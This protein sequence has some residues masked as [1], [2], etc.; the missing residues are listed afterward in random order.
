MGWKRRLLP[1]GTQRSPLSPSKI[2]LPFRLMGGG[3]CDI[4]GPWEQPRPA[5]GSKQARISPALLRTQLL[6]GVLPCPPSPSRR[7]QPVLGR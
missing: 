6:W 7:P 4:P 2:P 1:S 5:P 3:H